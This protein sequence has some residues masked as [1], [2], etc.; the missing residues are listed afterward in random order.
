MLFYNTEKKMYLQQGDLRTLPLPFKRT[1]KQ[2][3]SETSYKKIAQ[4]QRNENKISHNPSVLSAGAEE[5][6]K[7]RD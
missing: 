1:C 4:S 5:I 7:R 3:V 6:P 2:K